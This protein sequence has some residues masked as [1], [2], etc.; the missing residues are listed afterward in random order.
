MS[1]NERKAKRLTKEAKQLL[2]LI[3]GV[4]V[5]VAVVIGVTVAVFFSKN[6]KNPVEDSQLSDSVS[7]DSISSGLTV[8]D[9]D[10]D[11]TQNVLEVDKYTGT[12]LPATE[13]AG[14]E[15]V[16]ETL[17]IGDSNTYRYMTYAH[18]T[19]KNTIGI[20]SMGIQSVLTEK[21]V[22]FKGYSDRVTIPEAVKIM[23]PKRIIICF[24]TNNTNGDWS[25]EYMAQQ[26][27][28]VLDGIE[29]QWPYAD[30]IISAIPPVA[31]VRDAY[32]NISM[33]VIDAYNQALV[34]LAEERG[35]KFL[36]TSEVLKDA[37]TGFAMDGYTVSDGIHLAMPAVDALFGYVR[38]HAYETEDR[39]PT[40]LKP[41]PARDEPEPYNILV[42]NPYTGTVA[43]SGSSVKEGLEIVFDVNDAK[44]G[45][46]KGEAEQI[47]PAGEKCT[48]VEAVAKEGYNFAYWSCTV[49]RIEDVKNPKLTFVSPAGFDTERVV[50]TANFVKSGY[51]VKVVSSDEKV[52][53]AG[54]R[55]GDTLLKEA[56]VAEGK[57]VKL[58]ASLN[59]GYG[60]THL[61]TGWYIK[62]SVKTEP[63]STA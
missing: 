16:K 31:R 60:S 1:R 15:Y 27:A 40:P 29:A 44:M 28:A 59:E 24:G 42:E 63:I 50:V 11:P 41:V 43:G 5:L 53:T 62:G 2:L 45:E 13:D 52:G 17:F 47:V 20:Q 55:E 38:T 10:Y 19:L 7:G 21:C 32:Q 14:E 49:G 18:T 58:Y 23:Q 8:E 12:I 37:E 4:V 36:N 51:L 46:L 48:E 25:P 54:I 9:N 61:F 3:G 57:E 56:N 22:K 35:C 39:R 34:G 33:S 6:P 26:Y 30:I